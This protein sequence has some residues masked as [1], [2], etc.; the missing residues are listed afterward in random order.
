[1]KIITT[2]YMGAKHSLLCSHTGGNN[3]FPILKILCFFSLKLYQMVL[4]KSGFGVTI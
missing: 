1:M 3:Y 4:Y 2:T